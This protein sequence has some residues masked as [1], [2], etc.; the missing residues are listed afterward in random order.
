[1]TDR[2]NARGRVTTWRPWTA[3]GRRGALVWSDGV[4]GFAHRF[5]GRLQ[6]WALADV[7]PGRLVPWLAVA[8]GFGI[9]LYF[10]AGTEPSLW[11]A[12]VLFAATSAAAMLARRRPVA[13]PV[14]L[15]LATM[16]AGFATATTKRALVA[17]PVLQTAVW[18]V[19][20][21]GF[22]EVREERERSDRVVVRVH[23][24]AGPR[25]AES[26]DRVRVSVRKGTAPP[27][28]AFVAF[29]A[30]LTPP[31]QPVRPGGY[32]F[33]RNLY[34]QGIGAS[35]FVLGRI[36]TVDP[37]VPP[38]LRLRAAATVEATRDTIDNRIR[39]VLSGDRGSI[40]SA[41]ITGKRDAITTPVNDAMFVSGLG[42]VLSISGYHMAVVAG[43]MFFAV[44]A[45]F[46]LTPSFSSR[47]PIKKWAAVAAM[48]AAAFY[49]VLSGAEVATRRSFI[50][51]AIVLIGVIVDRPSLT[52]RTLTT[53]TIVVL[54]V[55]PEAVVHPSFQMS[56]AATLALVAGYEG[57]V[58]WMMA[59]TDSKWQTRIAL[60][61]GRALLG[62]VIVSLLAGFATTLYA[63]YHFHR[64][65]PYGVI[66][67]LLAMPVV[68]LWVMPMGILGVLAMPFGFDE[69]C[70]QLMGDGIGWMV[71]VALWVTALP[72]AVGR[73]PAFGVGPMLLGTAGL[74]V[75]CLLKSPLRH[76]GV[77]LIVICAYW[78]L[79][80]PQPDLLISADGMSL[81]VRNAQGRL[82]IV[83]YG[84]DSFA[85]RQWLA[86]D[87]DARTPNDKSLGEGI[88]CDAVGC[89]GR[90]AD[91][92]LVA[93]AREIEAFE[94][95]CRRAAVVVSAREAPPGCAAR[96]IDRKILQ[97]RGALA[98]RRVGHGFE[99]TAARSESYDRPWA[100]ALSAA[101]VQRPQLA[102]DATPRTEDLQH[103]E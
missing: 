16:A 100:K 11:A 71:S 86:A 51:V 82:A 80:T 91:G 103:G 62:L 79:H 30:R 4:A 39:A 102:R 28:G 32:D 72:G 31:L 37:P 96:V 44:R 42:H 2:N 90:L 50:M 53:A 26:P 17:H 35:G 20:I 87:A 54:L 48:A 73:V 3:T 15:A 25:L 63:A 45:L 95:D 83:R 98:L 78:A 6:A 36:R 57:G 60:W 52:L 19:E 67:N 23:R 58:P 81:A 89:V 10:T 97:R 59:T 84:G 49:L 56:F 85:A 14:A 77:G 13:F 93:L 33:A 94:E 69:W 40:A 65:A 61:G 43:L 8:F 64:L 47:Y 12:L 66:A 9:V 46:A 24:L 29:K 1:M 55:T 18:N 5:A 70:W 74:V 38:S 92:R 22:V 75:L 34:F 101:V 88:A 99:I 68:S 76:A 7:G 21:A 41:L 27:V